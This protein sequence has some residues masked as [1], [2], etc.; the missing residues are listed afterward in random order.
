MNNNNNNRKRK[1]RSRRSGFGESRE[2]S[3]VRSVSTNIEK[4][5]VI[6][7]KNPI[8]KVTEFSDKNPRSRRRNKSRNKNQ[9]KQNPTYSGNTPNNESKPRKVIYSENN[10][11]EL[12]RS[13][14]KSEMLKYIGPKIVK[15]V[16]SSIDRKAFLPY[17]TISPDSGV[18][19]ICGKNITNVAT[20]L[21][22]GSDGAIAHF[23]CIYDK[24][25]DKYKLNDNERLSYV[26]NGT[27]A[28]IEDY[29]EGQVYKFRIKE[30]IQVSDPRSVK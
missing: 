29:R 8:K 11:A 2:L 17:N 30:R 1:N 16:K 19:S 10:K 21:L 28:V 13:F 12:K 26:G 25:R 15:S 5:D 9:D 24:L 18:C 7:N 14:I 3:G 23:D 22:D 6:E 4:K 27:F 20:A